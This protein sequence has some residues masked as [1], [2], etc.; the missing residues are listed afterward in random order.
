M[1]LEYNRT[2]GG[3]DKADKLVIEYSCARRAT[4]QLEAHQHRGSSRAARGED[5]HIVLEATTG[6]STQ[7]ALNANVLSVRNTGRPAQL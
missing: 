3:V 5:A 1:I 6:K 4:L 7:S 2:K